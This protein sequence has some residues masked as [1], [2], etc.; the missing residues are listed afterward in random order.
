MYSI[1]KT[2]LKLL[3]S[4]AVLS[5]AKIGQFLIATISVDLLPY[6]DCIHNFS[7]FKAVDV[8]NSPIILWCIM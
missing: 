2:N 8:V 5:L 4:I 6:C 1:I 3:K 7:I